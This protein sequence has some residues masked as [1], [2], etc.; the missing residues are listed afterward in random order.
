MK[1]L[2]RTLALTLLT[3]PPLAR[4]ESL[5]AAKPVPEPARPKVLLIGLDGVSLN[6]LEPK[7]K[8]GLTPNLGRL[9]E[10][11]TR[12]HLRTIWPMRTPQVWTTAVTGK[13][14]GQ[15]GIWDHKSSTYFNPPEVRTEEK[16][17]VTT[18]DR[19]SKALWNILGEKG[20]KSLIVG[21]VPSWPAE[22]VEGSVIAA[23]IELMGDPRQTTIKGS[24]WRG[25]KGQIQPATLQKKLMSKIVEPGDL[26]PEELKA[27]ADIPPEGHELYTTVPRL[28]RYAYAI[29][30]S[31]ARAKSVEAI[32]LALAPEVRADL[33]LVYFQCT[34]SMLHRFWIFQKSEADI[35]VRYDT[36]G[37]DPVSI[38]EMK[39]R[40]GG[41]VDACYRDI[42]AR[43]GRVLEALAGPDT[44]VMIV[45]D[46][47]FGNAPVPHKLKGEPFSGDHLDDGVLL[48]AGP[49]VPAGAAV[50]G[51]KIEDVT[52][53]LLHYLGLPVG[54]DMKGRVLEGI[55]EKTWRKAHPV[56]TI[57]SYEAAPQTEVLHP[58]GYPERN[59]PLKPASAQMPGVGQS[60]GE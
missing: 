24:F 34:D 31:L 40:F 41:V 3:L 25:E 10:T 29:E 39:R 52:P 49:G 4:A 19:K 22:A 60:A 23:P 46:H 7:A 26:K 14:P 44:L 57:P 54:A 58:E 43:V 30:W 47:G 11:G 35:R 45:S 12:G 33:A 55:F 32:A 37:I 13:L 15:H 36:H 1:I 18:A 50:K 5:S 16:L 9:L 53:T 48:V 56:Q 2:I 28:D 51:A 21:W 17:V 8:A 42:D 20:M 59:I 27:W 38:P 6:L